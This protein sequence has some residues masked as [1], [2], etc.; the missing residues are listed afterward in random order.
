MLL[1]TLPQL[2]SICKVENF[3]S[4]IFSYPYVFIAGTPEEK[5][6]VCPTDLVPENVVIKED[7]WKGFFISGTLDF[8][9]VGILAGISDVLAKEKIGIFVVSTY[10]TDYIFVKEENFLSAVSALKKAGY[11]IE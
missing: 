7:G 9:L 4:D 8:S 2:F 3:L 5:S 10:N 6:L 1:K 11:R